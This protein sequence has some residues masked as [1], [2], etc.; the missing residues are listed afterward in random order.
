MSAIGSNYANR[1]VPNSGLDKIAVQAGEGDYRRRGS[2]CEARRVFKSTALTDLRSF[3]QQLYADLG[4]RQD[5]LFELLDSAL[6]SPDRRTL[7]R[8]SLN[9]AFRRRWPSTCDALS[10]GRLNPSAAPAV[11]PNPAAR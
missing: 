9:S 5:S 8:L 6:S 4:L 10:D 7:V 2:R 3:R 11:P 1:M